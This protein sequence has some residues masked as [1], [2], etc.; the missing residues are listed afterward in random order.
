MQ[1][2]QAT[3]KGRC[4]KTGYLLLVRSSTIMQAGGGRG[5][6]NNALLNITIVAIAIVAIAIVAIHIVANDI[7][8]ILVASI[9]HSI[10]TSP[11]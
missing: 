8:V 3:V 1:K 4:D 6:D 9:S 5:S 2:R 10:I 7:I 11:P